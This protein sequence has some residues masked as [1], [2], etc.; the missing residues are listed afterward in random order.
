MSSAAPSIPIHSKPSIAPGTDASK[1]N[2]Q[3]CNDIRRF[4]FRPNNCPYSGH[5][6][7]YKYRG[8]S[9]A[10]LKRKLAFYADDDY[11]DPYDVPRRVFDGGIGR[12]FCGGGKARE[13][14]TWI[15]S[16]AFD[17]C[18]GYPAGKKVGT[19]AITLDHCI[20]KGLAGKPYWGPY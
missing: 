5:D 12:Y 10:M 1:H 2:C 11:E 19:E 14:S 3:F 4:P 9:Q 15:T 20:G 16:C 17:D 18:V 6:I 8:T 13:I 7:T